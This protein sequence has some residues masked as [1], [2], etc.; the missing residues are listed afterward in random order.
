MTKGLP[1]R[2]RA[3]RVAGLLVLAAAFGPTSLAQAGP[4]NQ[5]AQTASG[6]RALSDLLT[7]AR[8]EK[9]S[10]DEIKLR[11][12]QLGSR[13]IPSALDVIDAGCFHQILPGNGR[14][15]HRLEGS[16]R[17]GLLLG[18]GAH[19]WQLLKGEVLRRLKSDPA[20]QR[21]STA[22][23]VFGAAL[24]EGEL[25][26]LLDAL[27]DLPPADR[28]A[29]RS[30]LAE[31]IHG[32][33]SRA[34]LAYGE[35]RELYSSVSPAFA[36]SVIQ[37]VRM[38]DDG[39][40]FECLTSLIGVF[41]DADPV[42]LMEVADLAKTVT[43]PV[44]GAALRPLRAALESPV[45]SVSVEAVK[46]LGRADDVLAIPGLI[47]QLRSS[48]A[49]MVREARAALERLSA[50]RFGTDADAW[51]TWHAG[52]LRWLDGTA[53]QLLGELKRGDTHR[54]NRALLQLARYR[55]FRHD[56][57][58]PVAA[59]VAQAGNPSQDQVTQLACAVLGH[60]ATDRSVPPLLRA[61]DGASVETRKA[62]LDALVRATGV[63][64]GELAA[65]WKAAGWQAQ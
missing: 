7:T 64:H 51:A 61:L 40:S 53:P 8:S 10:P 1:M 32:V 20:R 43:R 49:P 65:D 13:A 34:P 56:L 44:S 26:T 2:S 45:R 9:L 4:R 5:A 23:E 62:A 31:A 57:V 19:P 59:L 6:G 30:P 46:A 52:A 3:A 16:C 14:V 33:C 35:V 60:F 36:A 27:T 17:E 37:G 48:H 18:L 29:L 11:V 54:T 12:K 47:R 28:R 22:L 21:R 15:V 24:P 38:G 58:E 55:V 50:E 39:H 41:P 63:N 42:L 25:I